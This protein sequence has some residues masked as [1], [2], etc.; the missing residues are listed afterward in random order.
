[1]LCESAHLHRFAEPSS[2]YQNLNV[3][4]KMVLC[5]I[6]ARARIH[7]CTGLSEGYLNPNCWLE[8]RFVFLLC[9]QRKLW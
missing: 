8:Y 5:V 7:I 4:T 9:E 6:H 2:Q 3:L 1:M